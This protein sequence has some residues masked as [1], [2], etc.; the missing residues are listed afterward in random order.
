MSVRSWSKN[1]MAGPGRRSIVCVN[2]R[3]LPSDGA[4]VPV[5]DRGFQTG[6]GVFETMRVQDGVPLFLDAHLGRLKRSAGALGISS[7]CG[8]RR[9]AWCC[10]E[11]ASRNPGRSGVL[12]VTLTAGRPVGRAS[13][14]DTPKSGAR[15]ARGAMPGTIVVGF[16]EPSPVPDD[17]RSVGVSV[18]C[19]PWR[20]LRDY[21]L[22]RHKS[23]SFLENIIARESVKRTRNAFEAVFLT[24]DGLLL[25]G[26]MSNIFVVFG[27]RVAT[28]ALDLPVLPGITRHIVLG[29][30]R[31]LGLATGEEH[32]RYRSAGRASEMF[33]TNSVV[34]VL[35]VTRFDGKDVGTGRV[36]SITR[37]L[38]EE[39]EAKVRRHI[40]RARSADRSR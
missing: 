26:S 29:I 20:R 7:P 21:P 37:R 12:R 3:F 2:G 19:A 6:F 13:H 16:R 10:N 15:W 40:A 36:G 14:A 11:V 32:I 4:V 17:A 8:W 1:E 28:A 27:E 23:T 39:Y 34:G 22:A 9:T 24:P 5:Q 33:L 25:E 30:C 38:M 35:A 31:R 18:H